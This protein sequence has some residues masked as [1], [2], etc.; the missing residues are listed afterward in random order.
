MEER[1][2]SFDKYILGVKLLKFIVYFKFYK[3]LQEVGIILV[4][5][6]LK[7]NLGRGS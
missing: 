7:L 1:E 3:K 5:W 4:L 6:I 2:Q